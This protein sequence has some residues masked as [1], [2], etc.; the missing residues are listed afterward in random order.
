[1]AVAK[2]IPLLG[3]RPLNDISKRDVADLR[4]ALLTR[5]KPSAAQRAFDVF[6][7]AMKRA[8]ELDEIAVNPAPAVRRV[9]TAKPATAA[10][11][12]E[13]VRLFL[14]RA[15]DYREGRHSA[16]FHVLLLG[17]LRPSE[18]LALRWD[19]LQG[20]LLRVERAAT[21]DLE[22]RIV[23]GPTKTREARTVNLPEG[24][25]TALGKHRR[26]SCRRIIQRGTR[27]TWADGGQ[28]MFEGRD[29]DMLSIERV[30]TAWK[31][32]SRKAGIPKVRL[33]D[34]RHTYVTMLLH[35]GKDARTVADLA[36]HKDP[37]MTLRRYAHS[38]PTS[39][40]DAAETLQR[41]LASA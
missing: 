33:Y 3:A 20:S 11:T 1:M 13:Q 12:T 35:A 37:A 41:L 24:A 19:D 31:A 10:L 2:I 34:A 25:L 15:K 6:R 38:S 4:S 5:Y 28:L 27:S 16:L 9:S 21:E 18:A 23:A 30:R 32:I 22:G 26:D 17:G 40:R 36:G 8:Y 14:D 7:M 39:R 29:G